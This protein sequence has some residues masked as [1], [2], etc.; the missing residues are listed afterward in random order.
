MWKEWD[1]K[2]ALQ[3]LEEKRNYDELA[4]DLEE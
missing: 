1:D 3:L 4:E 2:L